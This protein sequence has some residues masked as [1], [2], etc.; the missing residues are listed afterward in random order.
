M[1]FLTCSTDSS[2][3]PSMGSLLFRVPM[4]LA[5][6]HWSSCCMNDCFCSDI[7][8]SLSAGLNS[9]AAGRL[10][11]SLQPEVKPPGALPCQWPGSPPP[12]GAEPLPDLDTGGW[13]L[14]WK[15]TSK[16]RLVFCVLFPAFWVL[17][18]EAGG[19]WPEGPVPSSSDR[20]GRRGQQKE[21]ASRERACSS[22]INIPMAGVA[23]W[24]Y[25]QPL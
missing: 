8:L 17:Q 12:P 23:S 18:W 5:S 3:S 19:S 20:A 9:L 24:N 16:A 13:R 14:Q 7:C 11:C 6:V 2:Q 4:T 15:T 21:Q 1:A 22:A 25:G 10:P